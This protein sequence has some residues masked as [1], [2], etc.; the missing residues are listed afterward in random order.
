MTESI[1]VVFLDLGDTLVIAKDGRRE[2]MP[3]AQSALERLRRK[4]VRLG[5]L[6]NTNG[7]DREKLL[8]ILPEDFSYEA[9]EDGLIVL[10][11][12]VGVEKPK[13][14]IYA[15][16]IKKAGVPAQQTIYVGEKEEETSAAEGTGMRSFLMLEFPADWDRL[17]SLID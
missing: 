7:Y 16:A 4:K 6:S 2:W 9:F 12:D 5:I 14:G 1:D 8:S 11:F 13:P 17:V 10:S 15:E 3:G